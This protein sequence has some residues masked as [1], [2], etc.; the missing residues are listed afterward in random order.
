MNEVDPP[1]LFG[2][3]FNVQATTSSCTPPMPWLTSN[4]PPTFSL[5]SPKPSRNAS[6]QKSNT[7]ALYSKS[8]NFSSVS[9]RPQNLHPSHTSPQ[10]SRSSTRNAPGTP[11]S[12]QSICTR[13]WR[14]HALPNCIME[15]ISL[16]GSKKILKLFTRRERQSKRPIRST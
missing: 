4:N 9:S 8:A 16:A 3:Y 6:K 1:S 12:W 14:Y 7:L 5:P 2:G 13:K 10:P 11:C 15:S